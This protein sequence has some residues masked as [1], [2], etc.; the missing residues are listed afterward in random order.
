MR[1]SLWLFAG[2]LAMGCTRADV[3]PGPEKEGAAPKVSSGSSQTAEL[4]VKQVAQLNQLSVQLQKVEDSRCPMNA[5]CI[6]QGSAIATL[7]VKDAAG[8]SQS[9]VLYLGEKLPAPNN[10]G[11]RSADSVEVQLGQKNYR[12][13]LHS[14]LPYPNTSAPTPEEKIVSVTVR[15]L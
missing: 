12:L 10:R 5:M 9:Q 8:N 6:R 4:K 14:V 3:S 2:M 1:K 7:E 13:I 15:S 11:D